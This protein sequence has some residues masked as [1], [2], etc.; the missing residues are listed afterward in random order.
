MLAQTPGESTARGL[1]AEVL[2]K[3]GKGDEAVAVLREGVAATSPAPV[4]HRALGSMLERTGKPAQAA[5][6]YREYVRLAPNGDDAALM[7]GR[8]EKLEKALQAPRPTGTK[9]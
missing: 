9:S 3:D 8:A 7:A 6:A 4:L 1:L 2:L 5:A